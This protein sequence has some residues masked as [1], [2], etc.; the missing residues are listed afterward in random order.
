MR[1]TFFAIFVI[2]GVA[3]MFGKL[4]NKEKLVNNLLLENVEA[5][6]AGEGG[7]AWCRGSGNT[8][9]PQIG[10]RV[11]YTVEPYNLE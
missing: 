1:K 8:I 4:S 10:I 2:A 7:G 3:V 11:A 5:L 6:A 9:C